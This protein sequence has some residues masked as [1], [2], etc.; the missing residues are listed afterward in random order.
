MQGNK[1]I[2]AIRMTIDGVGLVA[3]EMD[4][5][6]YFFVTHTFKVDEDTQLYRYGLVIDMSKGVNVLNRYEDVNHADPSWLIEKNDKVEKRLIEKYD[7]VKALFDSKFAIKKY[8][9]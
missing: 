9:L 1:K 7:Y 5:D 6:T 2:R 8:N 4:K 3:K